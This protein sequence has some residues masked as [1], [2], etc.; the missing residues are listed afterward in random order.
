M[1]PPLPHSRNAA[2]IAGTSSEE[3]GVV[4]LDGVGMQGTRWA[5]ENRETTKS[6][7]IQGLNIVK[8]QECPST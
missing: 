7:R 8:E 5:L 4:R 3:S 1:V 6:D 2:W